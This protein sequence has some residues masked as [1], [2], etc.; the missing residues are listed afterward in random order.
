MG[1]GSIT[2][3]VSQYPRLLRAASD[4]LKQAESGDKRFCDTNLLSAVLYSFFAMEAYLNFLGSRKLKHWDHLEAALN[5]KEKL[6]ILADVIGYPLDL[7][8]RPA[9]SFLCAKTTRDYVAHAKPMTLRSPQG[10][11]EDGSMTED[12][13]TPMERVDRSK[14]E[15]VLGDALAL[16]KELNQKAFRR[17]LDLDEDGRVGFSSLEHETAN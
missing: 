8:A 4:C 1:Q 6:C 5:P 11:P 3:F 10:I 9:Q 13:M 7:G 2:R 16:M 12:L 15:Q 14:A 17:R